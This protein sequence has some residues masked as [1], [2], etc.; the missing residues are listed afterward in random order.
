[1]EAGAR[2]DLKPPLGFVWI[3]ICGQAER[4]TQRHC[5]ATDIEITV[6]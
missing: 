5:T 3:Q 2:F 4:L 6:G 1:M